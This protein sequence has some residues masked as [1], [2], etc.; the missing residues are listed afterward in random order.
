MNKFIYKNHATLLDDLLNRIG[1]DLQLDKTR[2][3][4]METAYK[5]VTDW[6]KGDKG[7]FKDVS[8]DIYPHGSVSTGTTVKPLEKEEFDLD[9]VLHIHLDWE[10]HDPFNVYTELKR[11]LEENE[12]YKKILVPKNRVLRLNY[13]GDFHMDIMPGCQEVAYDINKIRVPD[14]KRQD[15]VSSSPRGFSFWFEEKANSV[16]DFLLEKA[17]S[18]QELPDFEPYSL[19][20]PLQRAVQLMKRHR[21]VYF[22]DN[23]DDA[24]S[25]IILTTLAGHFY[26]GEGT[27]Y[28]TIDNLIKRMDEEV[29][30]GIKNIK[31][32][33]PTNPQEDFTDKWREKPQLYDSFVKFTKEFKIS[34][35]AIKQDVELSQNED[36]LK[37][38]FGERT[39]SKAFNEQ[40][41]FMEKAFGNTSNKH[42]YLITENYEGLRSL[43][44]KSKPYLVQ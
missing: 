18:I 5:A 31:I 39:F 22:K 43:A 13:A 9:C 14:K 33:N 20:K 4:R 16:K 26:Q 29:R 2:Q 35:E 17:F 40:L 24:P 28:D 6:I 12:V 32:L 41:D 38:L 3:G 10:K 44:L 42:P 27:I 7:F 37:P 19:K 34:W 21:D 11:R 36:I 23:S 25:S 1:N 15:W 30:H 8:F